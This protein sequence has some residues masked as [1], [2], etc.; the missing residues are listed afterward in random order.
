MKVA[1]GQDDLSFTLTEKARR[2]KHIATPEELKAEEQKRRRRQD[3]WSQTDPWANI[4]LGPYER[5]YP[6]WDII[7]S[8][9]LVVQIE[10]Y[11][12]QGLRRRWADGRTQKVE[13][14]LDEIVIGIRAYLAGEKEQREQG[15][16]C[17]R[18]YEHLAKRR[19]KARLRRERETKRLTFLTSLSDQQREIARLK[20]WLAAWDKRGN[21]ASLDRMNQWARD[22]LSMLRSSLEPAGIESSLQE[23]RLFPLND[24]LHDPEGE[25]P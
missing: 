20:E 23:L 5:T 9:E 22:R 15:E 24:E 4:D 1:V 3:R 13:L 10:G 21:P 19:E 2:Q 18:K 25:S 8:G 6:E 17:Q 11:G 16:I 14:M 12:G 7:C